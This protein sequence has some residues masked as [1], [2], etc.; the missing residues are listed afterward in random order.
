MAPAQAKSR[1]CG[2]PG[3]GGESGKAIAAQLCADALRIVPA[4]VLAAMSGA[5]ARKF[6]REALRLRP[7]GSVLA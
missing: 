4:A 2:R 3:C 1:H 7:G 5:L 6:S